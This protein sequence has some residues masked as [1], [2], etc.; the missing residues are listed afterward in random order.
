MIFHKKKLVAVLRACNMASQIAI[1]AQE[2]L[3][4]CKAL[5][6]K[7]PGPIVGVGLRGMAW[8]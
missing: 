6:R 1:L 8:R 4:I 2:A 5:K 3:R 7:K